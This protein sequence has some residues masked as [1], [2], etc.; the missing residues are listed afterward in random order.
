MNT[1]DIQKLFSASWMRFKESY[2]F[3]VLTQIVFG[4]SLLAISGVAVL[5]GLALL[6]IDNAQEL[7]AIGAS[8]DPEALE[9]LPSP[10]LTAGMI[11][12]FILLTIVVSFVF[13]YIFIG[14]TK[15]YINIARMGSATIKDMFSASVRQLI[16]YVLASL[17]LIIFFFLVYLAVSLVS[18]I[19][20]TGLIIGGGASVGAIPVLSLLALFVPLILVAF[21]F[22][23]L[24]VRYAIYTQLIADN[25]VEGAFDSLKASSQ[26]V[27][28]K[29]W[30]ILAAIILIGLVSFVSSIVFGLVPLVGSLIYFVFVAP[31]ITLL[32]AM[33]YLQIVGEGAKMIEDT[34]TVEE[35]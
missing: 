2:W 25:A 6:G 31:F 11:A 16:S 5:G 28:G 17:M 4:L 20:F 9:S 1:V 33:L 10:E 18:G 12:G 8:Q 21:I 34:A 27:K 24:A 19:I 30:I 35:A 22:T 26:A 23:W 14:Y 3:L 32:G 13:S 15:L 29:F 7:I